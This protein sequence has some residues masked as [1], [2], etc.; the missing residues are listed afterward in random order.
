MLK[1]SAPPF[2]L[3]ALALQIMCF[4]AHAQDPKTPAVTANTPTSGAAQPDTKKDST[5][6]IREVVQINANKNLDERRDNVA[7]TVVIRHDEITSFGV[8]TLG[9]VL[10]R[11][12]GITVGQTQGKETEIRMR[13][14]GAGYTQVF[15]NGQP[16]PQGFSLDSIAPELIERIEIMRTPTAEYSAQAISGVINI[17]LI[18]R[19]RTGQR[20]FKIGATRDNGKY[21]PDLNVQLSDHGKG[22]SYSLAAGLSHNEYEKPSEWVD[23]ITDA[24]GVLKQLHRTSQQFKG[25]SNIFTISPRINWIRDDVDTISFQSLLKIEKRNSVYDEHT[26]RLFGESPIYISNYQQ[27]TRE[28]YQFRG[29]LNW[30]RKLQDDAKIDNKIGVNYNKRSSHNSNLV[31]ATTD[32]NKYYRNVNSLSREKG[33]FA[34]GKYAKNTEDGHSFIIGWDGSLHRRIENRVQT[35]TFYKVAKQ[36][37]IN[38]EYDAAVSRLA[39][40]AQDEWILNSHKSIYVGVRW[41]GLQTESK[42]NAI[43]TVHNS[44]RVWSPIFQLVWKLPSSKSDQIRIGLARTYKAP[45]TVD[46]MPRRFSTTYNSEVQPDTQG[47]PQLKPELAQGLDFAYERHYTGGG[48]IS[49]GASVRYIDDVILRV[50]SHDADKWISVPANRGKA[51]THSIELD[52]KFGLATVISGAPAIDLRA[53]FTRNWS[54]VDAIPGQNNRLSQQTPI[55]ANL[56]LDYQV[57]S[58]SITVGGNFNFQNGGLVKISKESSAYTSVKRTLDLYAGIKIDKRYQLK[59]MLN[60]ILNSDEISESLYNTEKIGISK[61]ETAASGRSCRIVLE[62]KI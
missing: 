41:E 14:L 62:I 25:D 48:I 2:R 58:T 46:L 37:F 5:A 54:T 21:S 44:Y 6:P 1:F 34:V 11:L 13:G 24:N 20:E 31:D 7:N 18:N 52:A 29:D 51:R 30:V 55:S 35:D 22:F 42:G 36:N 3:T 19:V 50:L 33:V 47:N 40:Y 28:I 8:V 12:P 53:N 45:S 32:D 39:F 23:Q 61:L 27:L 9:E 17:V 59:F 4:C 10:K 15:L 43:E 26:A 56:G 49:A 60:N 38:E 16:T 57:P